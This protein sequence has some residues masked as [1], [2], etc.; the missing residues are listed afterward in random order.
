[1]PFVLLF[2]EQI[3]YIFGHLRMEE[4]RTMTLGEKRPRGKNKVMK[5][6]FNSVYLFVYQCHFEAILKPHV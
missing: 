4:R 6:L 3:K 5:V 2:K 1:M